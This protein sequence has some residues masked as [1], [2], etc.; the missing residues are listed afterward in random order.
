MKLN[1]IQKNV[2]PA[3]GRYRF[4]RDLGSALVGALLS[5]VIAHLLGMSAAI[6]VVADAAFPGYRQY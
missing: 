1:D 4:W 6:Q 2:V 5:G 3:I